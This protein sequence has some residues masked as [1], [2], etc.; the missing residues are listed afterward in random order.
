MSERA[1]PL[2][3]GHPDARLWLALAGPPGAGKSALAA[4]LAARWR[5]PWLDK[6][7]VRAAL[8]GARWTRF[9]KPQDD[10]VMECLYAAAGDL[11]RSGSAARVL[12]DGR[13]F[14]LPS[15]REVLAGHAR[16]CGAHCLLVELWAPAEVLRERVRQDAPDHPARDR[17]R[18]LERQLARH[19]P[20]PRGSFERAHANLWRADTHRLRAVEV[21]DRLDA[22]LNDSP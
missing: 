10:L 4:E 13:T 1:T 20:A 11:V 5:V 9:A 3:L 2:P 21:A 16:A 19:G 7:R 6:D 8:F 15:D 22:A 12:L 18:A 14:A 17:S